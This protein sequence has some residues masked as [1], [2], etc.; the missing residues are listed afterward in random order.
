MPN[1]ND[2]ANTSASTKEATTTTTTATT[3]RTE[4]R[5]NR[6]STGDAVRLLSRSAHSEN[7]H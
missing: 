3:I 6:W 2:H 7:E 5:V 4:Q 1:E